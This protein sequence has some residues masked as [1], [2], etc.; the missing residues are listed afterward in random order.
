MLLGLAQVRVGN[1]DC[2][3]PQCLAPA[4]DAPGEVR[5]INGLFFFPHRPELYLMTLRLLP[6]KD[7]LPH[8][9]YRADQVRDFDRQAIERFR[10]SGRELMYRAG[11]A[12][13]RYARKRWPAA[14]K[15][16]VL[17]GPGNNGGDGYVFALQARAAGLQ[18]HVAQLGD[19]ERMAGDAAEY[20]AQWRNSG[21]GWEEF[22]GIPQETDLIVDGIL[23]TGLRNDLRGAYRQAVEAANAHRAPVLALDI[24]TGLHSDTGVM[25]GGAIK[26]AAT[27][28]FIGLKQ[29]MFTADGVDCC[30]DIQFEG[31]SVPAS[32]YAGQVLAARRIC[33]AKES[34]RLAPR[35][36]SAHKGHFGHVLVI[37]GDHGFGGAVRLAA[38]AAARSGAGLVSVATRGAHVA[39]LLA[40]RPELMVHAVDHSHVLEPLLR[41]ATVVVLGPGLGTGAWGRELFGMAL[42]T[43]LPLVLDA[44]G[45]NLL[46]ELPTGERPHGVDWIMTPHPGEAARLLDTCVADLKTDRFA[47]AQALQRRFSAT[48]VLKGAGSIVAAPGTAPPAVC[49]DGNPGMASG[50][51]G[52]V[53]AGL[54]GGLRAQGWASR[55]ALELGVCLHAAAADAA[56][57]KGERGLLASALMTH[58]RPMVNPS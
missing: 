17:C 50:G 33:W 1:A 6:D 38:E 43:R 23:G 44:D 21:G 40:A 28:S 10:I 58:I 2:A 15:L 13:F 32:V 56:V 4:L 19:A 30:G 31:L 46:S 18:V 42:A 49:S 29:G 54:V 24:P 16:L 7:A 41:R 52:D 26:A 37:G 53:L 55:D 12:A 34:R 27:V 57:T 3:E 39:G 5:K 8:A 25:L 45:L 11:C 47:A 48:V 51:M 9:L 36:R 14:R 22:R 35:R 20:A